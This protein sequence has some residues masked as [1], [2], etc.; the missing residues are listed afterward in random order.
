MCVYL[1]VCVCCVYVCA[2]WDKVID[3]GSKDNVGRCNTH[4]IARDVMWTTNSLELQRKKILNQ[5]G[6]NGIDL[7]SVISGSASG[8]WPILADMYA[9]LVL[10]TYI[11]FIFM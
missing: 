6:L 3:S 8:F 2:W 9:F 10:P 11:I 4:Y 7:I 1:C 5:T